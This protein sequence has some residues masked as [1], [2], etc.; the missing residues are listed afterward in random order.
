ME[1]DFRET[2]VEGRNEKVHAAV[3]ELKPTE[4]LTLL[5]PEPPDP[6]VES[7]KN[8]FPDQL[9]IQPVRWGLKDLPWIL[10][11]KKSLKPSAYHPEEA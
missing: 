8:V 5:L 11:V 9:D 6:I 3:S 7:L 2:P 4:V 1:I 10:H